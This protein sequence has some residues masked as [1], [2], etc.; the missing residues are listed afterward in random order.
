M[1]LLKTLDNPNGDIEW[2]QRC[3]P[4]FGCGK[5]WRDLSFAK[6]KGLPNTVL[7]RV[8]VASKGRMPLC[9]KDGESD[10]QLERWRQQAQR[11]GD[12]AGRIFRETGLVSFIRA[13]PVCAAGESGEAASGDQFEGFGPP[14]RE[15]G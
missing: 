5:S 2:R 10:Q 8:A 14:G 9:D 7:S 3:S 12:I 1:N 6:T 15:W 13:Q 4:L 11:G